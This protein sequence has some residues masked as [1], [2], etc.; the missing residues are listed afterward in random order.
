MSLLRGHSGPWLSPKRPYLQGVSLIPRRSAADNVVHER[1]H[2]NLRKCRPIVCAVPRSDWRIA[3][4]RASYSARAP[5]NAL[6][7]ALCV[8]SLRPGVRFAIPIPAL[9]ATFRPKWRTNPPAPPHSRLHLSEIIIPQDP[10][11]SATATRDARAS[12]RSPPSAPWC[13]QRNGDY[14]S[15]TA[16]GT[17]DCSRVRT[18]A[19]D[20]RH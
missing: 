8:A 18:P 6:V 3:W 16:S 4:P 9:S 11:R 2:V 15:R 1:R 20:S 5:R 19:Q 12:S 10:C 7:N 14:R 17:S 13:C